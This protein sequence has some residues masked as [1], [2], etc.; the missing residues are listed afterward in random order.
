MRWRLW[1][2]SYVLAMSFSRG[3]A[4]GISNAAYIRVLNDAGK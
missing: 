2:N 3:F 1:L 4:G